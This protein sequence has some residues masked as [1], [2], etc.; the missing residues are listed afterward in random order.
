[1]AGQFRLYDSRMHRRSTYAALPMAL[2]ES[3]SKKDVRCLRAAIRNEG[4]I[5]S[6][7]KVGILKV[8]VRAAVTRGRHVDQASSRPNERRNP[9]DQDKVAQV[10]RPELRF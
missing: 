6:P 4:I 9:V 2:V 10:I 1:M 8:H 7:L 3:C 5:R